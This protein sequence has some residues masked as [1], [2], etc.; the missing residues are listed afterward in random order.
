MQSPPHPDWKGL[1]D[2]FETARDARRGLNPWAKGLLALLA[3]PILAAFWTGGVLIEVGVLGLVVL[4]M[5]VM[6][7][8]RL[9][10]ARE[11]RFRSAHEAVIERLRNAAGQPMEP[12]LSTR[13]RAAVGEEAE[14][15]LPSPTEG[16]ESLP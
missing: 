8:R 12:A 2:E 11:A 7:E 1:L 16:S 5:I 9:G 6:R 14:A 13:I 15:L 10:Q 3:L 4:T